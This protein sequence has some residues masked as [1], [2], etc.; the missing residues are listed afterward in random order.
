MEF[1]SATEAGESPKE[2]LTGHGAAEK[3]L[4]RQ[5]PSSTFSDELKHSALLDKSRC[6]KSSTINPEV[7]IPLAETFMILL[8]RFSKVPPIDEKEAM[9]K[10]KLPEFTPPPFFRSQPDLRTTLKPM[11]WIVFFL[12][13]LEEKY[14]DRP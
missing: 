10:A 14:T 8:N 4:T 1:G 2:A 7:P 12:L 9:A 13:C 3:V 11:F 5:T 6:S